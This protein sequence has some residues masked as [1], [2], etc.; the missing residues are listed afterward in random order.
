MVWYILGHFL[1]KLYE[2]YGIRRIDV[3]WFRETFGSD[4]DENL[5]ALKGF[6]I[7]KMV[8]NKCMEINIDIAKKL[9]DLLNKDPMFTD[10]HR[11]L[12]A[13]V[14]KK[15]DR[16]IESGEIKPVECKEG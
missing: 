11:Y 15:I 5:E 7:I 10:D 16:K 14:I 6:D 3:E 1:Y 2:V 4:V 8:G 13:Q 9:N 12:T